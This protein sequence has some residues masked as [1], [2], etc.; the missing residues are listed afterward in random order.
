MSV[1]SAIWWPQFYDANLL[2]IKSK[3]YDSL[4]SWQQF[5]GLLTA[6]SSFSDIVRPGI[7]NLEGH[8]RAVDTLV[9]NQFCPI[10][11]VNELV[12]RFD[13]DAEKVYLHRKE[14]HLDVVT[15]TLKSY[16]ITDSRFTFYHT[17]ISGDWLESLIGQ[18]LNLPVSE[19]VDMISDLCTN[20]NLEEHHAELFMNVLVD[21]VAETAAVKPS[22]GSEE[23]EYT[24]QLFEA[25]N[26]LILSAP[27]PSAM[28]GQIAGALPV[29]DPVLLQAENLGLFGGEMDPLAQSNSHM[30]T[31]HA[32]ILTERHLNGVPVKNLRHIE[33][34]WHQPDLWRKLFH[35]DPEVFRFSA[36][37]ACTVSQYNTLW[38]RF[39]NF[40]IST[41]GMSS[42][43]WAPSK[44]LQGLPSLTSTQVTALCSL[45]P[46]WTASFEELLDISQTF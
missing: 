28:I 34:I 11:M 23:F 43:F 10:E 6:P 9:R 5:A 12:D 2:T 46:N 17:A 45:S 29:T 20:D 1:A 32:K 39:R 18:V 42:M 16:D 38:C 27:L 13:L 36:A 25:F 30:A 37:Q 14:T 33:W 4:D 31:E 35:A 21:A 15:A 22:P 40:F 41:P 19:S 3:H 7:D 24:H 26:Q 44:P 8:V